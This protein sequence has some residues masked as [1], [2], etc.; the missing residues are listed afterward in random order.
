MSQ[1][2]I[3]AV[4]APFCAFCR[5][6]LGGFF[7]CFHPALPAKTGKDILQCGLQQSLIPDAD[8]P[9]SFLGNKLVKWKA[10][11][12]FGAIPFPDFGT[13]KRLAC[14]KWLW[15]WG[16]TASTLPGVTS[17]SGTKTFL[18]QAVRSFA[19]RPHPSHTL[20][21]FTLCAED[22]IITSLKLICGWCQPKRGVQNR[23]GCAFIRSRTRQNA[24][25]FFSRAYALGSSSGEEPKRLQRREI[26]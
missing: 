4:S 11:L 19:G 21:G 23:G 12:S 6:S 9:A 13:G 2:K 8:A 20:V 3:G 18:P 25:R 5:H 22:D 17:A 14:T 24:K 10:L 16:R 7:H 26:R 1:G 15:I